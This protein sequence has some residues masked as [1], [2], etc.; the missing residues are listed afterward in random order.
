MEK[1]QLK[2]IVA[3]SAES[4]LMFYLNHLWTNNGLDEVEEL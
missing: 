2:S 1:F 4:G 3:E